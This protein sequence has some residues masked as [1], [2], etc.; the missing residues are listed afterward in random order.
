MTA[1]LRR[2]TPMAEAAP[3]IEVQLIRKSYGTV[4]A[5]RDVS[6]AFYK[7]SVHAIVGE[8]GAGKSTLMKLIYGVERPDSGQLL[9]DGQ[10]RSFRNPRQ[11]IAHKI[12]M[13]FQHVALVPSLSALDNI[14]LGAE[15]GPGLRIDRTG[16]RTQIEELMESADLR[17]ALD[18]SVTSMS[19]A[20]QQRLE[21]VKSL[22]RGAEILILDEPTALLT[23]TERDAL[24]GV[25]RS[26]ADAGSAVLFITHK[27]GEVRAVAD[28]VTVL[29][30]G[31]VTGSGAIDD[32]SDT[33]LI[34]RMVGHVPATP[35]RKP[36]NPGHAV[37]VVQDLT[38]ERVR[39]AP[40][41][42]GID[43][44]VRAGE[45]VGIIGVDGN[46]QRETLQAIAGTGPASGGIVTLDGQSL[47]QLSIS[48]RRA[49]GLA[50]VPEDRYLEGVAVT[51]SISDNLNAN[52]V[53]RRDLFAVSRGGL[54]KTNAMRAGAGRLVD[55]FRIKIGSLEDPAGTL[56]GGNCQKLILARELSS[57]PQLLLIAEP[58]RGLDVGAAALVHEELRS[59]ARS[60]RAVLLQTS[61]IDEVLAVA[62]R[63]AVFYGGRIT[64][65]FDAS[66][67]PDARAVGRSMLGLSNVA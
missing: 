45:I 36:S 1:G 46:G 57:D 29:R 2:A 43:L 58:T 40:I 38:V 48:Q 16:E 39:G 62:D 26:L 47:E 14:A 6:A 54:L 61:D 37:L 18:E 44:E 12:G 13:V 49:A 20:Q 55:R 7:G 28:S 4:H 27:M 50:H 15:R 24:L 22:Y 35:V 51:E 19:A 31:A 60:G 25:I 10:A 33:E 64:E 59:A 3:A 52:A 21:I 41:V 34:E 17:V 23:P 65:W 42:A 8:N 5:V 32:F 63:I 53:A 9:I 67:Q 11:A 56:S 30:A 66:S